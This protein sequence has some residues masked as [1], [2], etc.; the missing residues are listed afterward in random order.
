MNM[1]DREW[2]DL[3]ARD[4]EFFN[5]FRF[6]KGAYEEMGRKVRRREL[7][8]VRDIIS[9]ILNNDIIPDMVWQKLQRRHLLFDHMIANERYWGKRSNCEYALHKA[10]RTCNDKMLPEHAWQA[11][12]SRLLD[13]DGRDDSS[14]LTVADYKRA[15][16]AW[17]WC[18]TSMVD[19]GDWTVPQCERFIAAVI[20]PKLGGV[21]FTWKTVKAT[22]IRIR[23]KTNDSCTYTGVLSDAWTLASDKPKNKDL[24]HRP[25]FAGML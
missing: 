7:Y 6:T 18:A 16:K 4:P 9:Y 23:E 8:K 25:R 24:E 21:V 22:C 14:H 1:T 5:T 13:G 20:A 11:A 12:V 19:A 17:C 2:E 3:Q 15:A 10:A